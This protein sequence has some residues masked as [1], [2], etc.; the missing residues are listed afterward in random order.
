M[1]ETI[2]LITARALKLEPDVLQAFAGRLR[3]EGRIL[4]WVGEKDPDLPPDLMPGRSVKIAGSER[5]RI[6][7]LR[8]SLSSELEHQR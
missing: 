7:E 2:D 3:P 5:R 4:L 1:P 8:R 6:L